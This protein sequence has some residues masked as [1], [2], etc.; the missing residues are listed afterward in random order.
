M[1]GTNGL[2]PLLCGSEPHV[3]PLNYIPI[4]KMEGGDGV[5]PSLWGSKPQAL[6][7]SYPPVLSKMATLRR[8]ELRSSVRQTDV[9][10]AIQQGHM[11]GIVG[12]EPT[13]PCSQGRYANQTA[14]HPDKLVPTLGLKP[15]TSR[16]SA[17]CSYQLSYMG[18]LKLGA[19]GRVEL[20]FYGY[21]PCVLPL[22][23]PAILKLLLISISAS[24][25]SFL[26]VF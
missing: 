4:F 23:D 16:L 2:E 11:V 17:G 13:T 10:T 5:E 20:P 25:L 7:L 19:G 15:R 24:C 14:L 21:E 12:F 8:V 6:P 1:E 18:S 26:N 3:L 9:I 22:Y